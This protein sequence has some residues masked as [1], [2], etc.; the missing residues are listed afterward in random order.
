LTISVAVCVAPPA[1]AEIVSVDVE[2]TPKVLIVKVALVAP[3]ATVTVAGTV[4]RFVLLLR[5]LTVVPPAGAGPVSVTVPVE[6]EPPTTEEGDRERLRTE[7]GGAVVV[8]LAVPFTPPMRAATV[9]APAEAGAVYR[10]F[11]STLPPPAATDQVTL[12][13][14]LMMAPNWSDAEAVNCCVAPTPTVAV[15]GVTETAVTVAFTVT[16][17]V[18]VAVSPAAFVRT[19]WNV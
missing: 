1:A 6:G 2:F 18:L 12:G 16:L 15:D 8:T 11:P 7:G 17:T 9:A 14:G 5:R 4:A 10:P 13:R 3:A 19:T